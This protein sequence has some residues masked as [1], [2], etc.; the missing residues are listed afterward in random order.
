[1]LCLCFYSSLH[2]ALLHLYQKTLG[3]EGKGERQ[4][5][6]MSSSKSSRTQRSPE[7]SSSRS[8]SSSRRSVTSL[9]SSAGG[10]LDEV[11]NVLN[12]TFVLS[13]PQCSRVRGCA[14]LGGTEMHESP[15]LAGLE[16][17]VQKA[18][19]LSW[20]NWWWKGISQDCKPLLI[21]LPSWIIFGLH[22]LSSLGKVTISES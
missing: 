15:H 11:G 20:L 3:K 19:G 6:W 7:R 12:V 22:C 14:W 17:R 1:M 21:L 8:H 5:I 18:A 10:F 9:V 4:I 13:Q 16:T 2:A